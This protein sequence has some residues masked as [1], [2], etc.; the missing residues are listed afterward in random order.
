MPE[1][2]ITAS[3][4][5]DSPFQLL[6][7]QRLLVRCLVQAHKTLGSFDK[8]LMG[9][10]ASWEAI[11]RAIHSP[12][13][14]DTPLAGLTALP[15]ARR[16][17]FLMECGQAVA[18]FA[19]T[20][21]MTPELSGIKSPADYL[22]PGLYARRHDATRAALSFPRS[23]PADIH[24]ARFWQDFW[25]RYLETMSY[26]FWTW[27]V[28]QKPLSM[29]ERDIWR[30][31]GKAA[32]SAHAEWSERI[33]VKKIAWRALRMKPTPSAFR[34]ALVRSYAKRR[35]SSRWVDGWL[36]HQAFDRFLIDL[37]SITLTTSEYIGL[38]DRFMATSVPVD[39]EERLIKGLVPKPVPHD[40][41]L[42]LRIRS[43]LGPTT[44][45]TKH[46]SFSFKRIVY[47]GRKIEIKADDPDIVLA[48]FPR[49]LL[50]HGSDAPGV[51]IPMVR[52]LMDQI[53]YLSRRGIDWQA[54]S[55]NY[56]RKGAGRAVGWGWERFDSPL[57]MEAGK[58]QSNLKLLAEIT[59]RGDDVGRRCEL[60]LKYWAQARLSTLD[61]ESTFLNL[62]AIVDI[63]NPKAANE[64]RLAST[65]PIYWLQQ[66]FPNETPA[67]LEEEYKLVRGQFKELWH[68]RSHG[69]I[70]RE[71]P[72]WEPRGLA[73]WTAILRDF[74]VVALGGLFN[75][76]LNCKKCRKN[77]KRPVH[78]L[79]VM[80]CMLDRVRTAGLPASSC[81]E[82]LKKLL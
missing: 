12:A 5:S 76:V 63:I 62:W 72:S 7:Q 60:A 38:L 71:K 82:A 14:G 70:H 44:V 32:K 55:I 36:Y 46:L 30:A 18:R 56:R 57:P 51:C 31:F 17:E 69:V 67:A 49:A 43:P 16:D 19:H 47:P 23:Y 77:R 3:S 8:R 28:K 78:I 81:A 29:S 11:V 13:E 34:E 58:M 9:R 64:E 26:E 20:R 59:R 10:T 37:G 27:F 61:D 21:P 50:Q 80:R 53:A 6:L 48:H 24:P 39:V 45:P 68:I 74:I 73:I 40:V 54:I 4:S 41:V 15:K 33:R 65:M 52:G 35:V 2:R 25:R 42:C 66:K 22:L 79:S 75:H 1:P